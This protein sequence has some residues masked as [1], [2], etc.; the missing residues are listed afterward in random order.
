M[1]FS[2]HYAHTIQMM[3]PDSLA[4]RTLC[5]KLRPVFKVKEEVAYDKDFQD[6][7]KMAMD[8]WGD[9]RDLGLPVFQ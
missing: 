4:T 2:D 7:V 3:V 1:A 8:E 6:R 5:P 9:V